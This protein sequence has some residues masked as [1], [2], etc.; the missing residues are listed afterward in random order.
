MTESNQ[1]NGAVR[2]HL[3]PLG[4]WVR[5]ESATELGIPDWSYALR[6][7]E[8]WLEAKLVPPSRRCPP[9]VTREQIMWAERRTA[10]GGR[11][12]LLGLEPRTRTWL[13][14]DAPQARAWFD[15]GPLEATIE[16]TG[17]FPTKPIALALTGRLMRY[18]KPG[19]TLV[20]SGVGWG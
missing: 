4:H 17:L 15:G 11:W 19:A 20:I 3:G 18:P 5:I 10:A 2:R 7:G 13:L 8:G 12:H 1:V 14:L 9:T 16:T 6:H